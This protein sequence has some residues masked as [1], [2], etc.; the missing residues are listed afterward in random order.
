MPSF[1]NALELT[2][3]Q[4]GSRG[5]KSYF[6]ART[7]LIGTSMVSTLNTYLEKTITIIDTDVMNNGD[8]GKIQYLTLTLNKLDVIFL[9]ICIEFLPLVA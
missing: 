8:F 3:R 9:S 2:A 5:Q 6:R 1:K 4:A 7:F